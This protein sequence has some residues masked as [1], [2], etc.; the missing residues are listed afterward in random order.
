[1]KDLS[2]EFK[3]VSKS[4][5]LEKVEKDLKGKAL[6]ELNWPF[7]NDDSVTPFF[8][9]EDLAGLDISPAT[10][11][12]NDW[13]CTEYFDLNHD[14]ISKENILNALSLGINNLRLTLPSQETGW[15]SVDRSKF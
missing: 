2:S 8:H 7:Q 11:K 4:A 13:N 10:D 14:S 15:G 12:N 3:P 5:W 6:T 1:M 9:K